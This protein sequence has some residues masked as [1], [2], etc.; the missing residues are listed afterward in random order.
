MLRALQDAFYKH[1][2]DVYIFDKKDFNRALDF[3]KKISAGEQSRFISLELATYALNHLHETIPD[4]NVIYTDDR[5][6]YMQFRAL[7]GSAGNVRVIYEN[8]ETHA[9]EEGLES[10]IDEVIPKD[11]PLRVYAEALRT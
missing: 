3:I 6:K 8:P 4:F 10:I 1:L 9:L 11:N 2:A 7:L 5:K